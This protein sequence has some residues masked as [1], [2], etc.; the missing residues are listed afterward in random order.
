[1]TH[2]SGAAWEFTPSASPSLSFGSLGRRRAR[3][4]TADVRD[5]SA[6]DEPVAPIASSN[7]EPPETG[8]SDYAVP[9]FSSSCSRRRAFAERTSG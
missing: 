6:P 5:P 9:E 4:Q 8:A 3:E 1:M 2:G 7:F